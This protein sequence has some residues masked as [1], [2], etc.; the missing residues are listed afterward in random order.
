MLEGLGQLSPMALLASL[1]PARW[2]RGLSVEEGLVTTGTLITGVLSILIGIALALCS[3]RAPVLALPGLYLIVEGALRTLAGAMGQGCALFGLWL[4]ELARAGIVRS[5]ASAVD[6]EAHRIADEMREEPGRLEL[7][8]AYSR[9]WDPLT[10]IEIRGDLYH[11]TSYVERPSGV[12]PHVYELRPV[13]PGWIIRR[14]ES[15]DSSQGPT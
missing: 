7:W 14:R 10:T 3:W 5:R 13:P 1:L 9:G 8:S 15:Y 12:R 6:R 4:V 11:V 2:R